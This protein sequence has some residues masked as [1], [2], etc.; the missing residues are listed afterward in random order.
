MSGI[1]HETILAHL[2][3]KR[4]TTPSGWTSFNAP[5]CVHNGTGADTR[6]RGGLIQNAEEGVSYHCFNCGYTASWNKGRRITYK[7]KKF[8]QWIN[9]SDDAINKLSLAVLQ[10]ES[11]ELANTITRMPEF[12]TVEL[13]EGAKP[14]SEYTDTTDAHLIKV[15][16]YMKSRQLYLEDYNFYWTPKIGYRDRLIVP[17]YFNNQIVG[18]TARK[19][20]DGAPKY[21]SEQQPGYVFNMDQQDYRRQFAIVVEGPMDAIGIEGLALLG[22]EVKD[23]QHLLIKSLNK[24][25]ILV[26]DRD[27]AGHK[28]IEQAIEFGWSVSMPD[29]DEDVNDVNDAITKYGRI[30]TLHQIVTH[31]ESSSLK[32][33]L[34]SKKW[35]G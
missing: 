32:I 19:V 15:L 25:V 11:D 9:V 20:T 28:L 30:Y 5:C 23:Q 33:K 18:Y 16:E 35:F 34:R 29:W 2:P 22:S 14:I 7:M 13:P 17:F 10:Y 8:L 27:E 24:Q 31:A 6:Q 4:K 1:V 3:A 21:M 26:P 12:K